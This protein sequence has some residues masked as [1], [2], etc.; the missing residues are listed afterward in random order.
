LNAIAGS[1]IMTVI[2][3]AVGTP[4]GMLAGTYLAEYGRYSSSLLSCASSTTSCSAPR[5][6]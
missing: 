3:V 4:V 1:V 2:A 6:S 5:R